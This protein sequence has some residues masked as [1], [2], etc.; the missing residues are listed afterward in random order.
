M[1]KFEKAFNCKVEIATYNSADE[2]IAKLSSGAVDFDLILG[3]TGAN[4]VDLIAHKLLQPLNHSYLP[5][6]EKNIWPELHSPCYDVGP[7][8]SV[9]SEFKRF[10]SYRDPGQSLDGLS[11]YVYPGR[12]S[13][14][15]Q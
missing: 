10:P 1:K 14:P 13:T 6:L 11:Q 9:N 4:I 12:F 5:N 2:A 8:Y 3:L 7:R 15:K